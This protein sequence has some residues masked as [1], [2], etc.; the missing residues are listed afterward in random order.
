VLK[1]G[2]QLLIQVWAMKQPENSRRKFQKQD[3]LLEFKSPDHTLSELRYYHVFVE[4][5][6]DRMF[7]TLSGI[8]IVN[9]YWEIGNWILLVEKNR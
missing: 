4:G 9:S 2:G 8:T 5:E 1:P 6:L 7:Q 3:N